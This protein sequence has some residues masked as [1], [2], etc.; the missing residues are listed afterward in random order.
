M[1]DRYDHFLD[2]LETVANKYL[3][4]GVENVD[5]RD[6]IT[7]VDLWQVTSRAACG[8]ITLTDERI[9]KYE[10]MAGWLINMYS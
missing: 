3:E 2:K 8:I 6:I 5:V 9:T 7:L 10:R 1:N 4:I